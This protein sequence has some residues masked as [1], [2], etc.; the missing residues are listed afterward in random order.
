MIEILSVIFFMFHTTIKIF[1]V[2]YNAE[3]GNNGIQPI[4]TFKQCTNTHPIFFCI[5]L[6]CNIYFT[7]ELVSAKT[8]FI[9]TSPIKAMIMMTR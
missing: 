6:I 1:S 5:D 4:A 2:S 9:N 7:V 8:S 3:V